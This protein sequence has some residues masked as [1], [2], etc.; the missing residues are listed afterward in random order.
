MTAKYLAQAA[1][2]Q[3]PDGLTQMFAPGDHKVDGT[4]IPDWTL[5][6]IL[7]AADHWRLT[8][9]RET[10]EGIYPSILKALAW[11]ERLI[12]PSG[13]VADMP[14]WH[15]MDWAGVGR[16]GEAAA[17]NAQ[18]AGSFRAAAELGH[19]VG[20]PRA[21]ETC[22]TKAQSISR[23]LEARHWD[24]RRKVYVDVVCPVSGLQDL[25]VSQH[26]NAAIALWGDPQS[27]RIAAALDRIV[28]AK[29]LTFTAAPPIAPEGET[30]DPEEGVVLAN[31]FY[32]H[33]V[34]E[35]LAKHGRLGD[36]LRLMQQRFGPMLARG[37]TTLWESFEPTA[38]LC[39]GFSASPTY[40]LSR[41]VLGVF[42]SHPGFD[43]VGLS[44]D[45]VDLE[46][47]DGVV[48]TRNGD[49][50]VRLERTGEGFVAKAHSSADAPIEFGMAPGLRLASD[51]VK[52]SGGFEARY[53][54]I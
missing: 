37:A 13:L 33:F 10:I 23:A 32:S 27:K 52:T 53:L 8:G 40:Q 50:Q 4:L 6:W 28:D 34:Y 17:L 26:A 19:A 36:A 7:A 21:A 48:P 43:K 42:P 39:H 30:L 11:F 47:A 24:E 1:E 46:Y 45:L 16:K 3:R 2:S 38:S 41:R 44:P 9:D 12:D 54:R 5:Q 31:T 14:Y 49:V 29:R 51:P 20:W 25:R 15:F 35:A 18:L 22:L